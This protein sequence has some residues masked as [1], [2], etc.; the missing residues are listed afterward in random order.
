MQIIAELTNQDE[1][2]RL[3]AATPELNGLVLCAGKNTMQ[4][5]LFST[6]KKFDDV[7]NTNFFAP[8]ELLRLLVK[9]KKMK[10]GSSVVAVVSV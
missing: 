2:E 8:V 1:V 3:V 10:K 7:F 4:P 6:R 9:N 5:F